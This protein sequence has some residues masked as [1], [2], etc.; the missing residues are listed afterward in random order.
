MFVSYFDLG[1]KESSSFVVRMKEEDQE[2][3]FYQFP[4]G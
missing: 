2:A 4:D 1:N 3:V